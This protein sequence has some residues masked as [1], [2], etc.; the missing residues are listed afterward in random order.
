MLTE[1]SPP[2]KGQPIDASYLFELTRAV[3][4]I[5]KTIDLRRGT[6]YVKP[7]T[8]NSVV[9]TKSTANTSFNAS[10]HPISPPT[11]VTAATTFS[12]R[13]DFKG[14][15]FDG[16]PVVTATPVISG[17]ATD[18]TKSTTVVLS[19]I[20]KGGFTANFKW[21]VAGPVKDLYLQV[22]AIGYQA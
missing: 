22:I 19:G 1:I 17:T 21:S 5:I 12:V 11:E 18:A 6:T 14:T 7:D 20:D 9:A 4:T 8:T 13:I 10:T 16:P 2:T 3:N 15:T